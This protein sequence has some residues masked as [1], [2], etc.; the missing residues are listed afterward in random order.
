MGRKIDLIGKRFNKLIV[1]KEYPIRTPQGSV[2]WECLC[3][4]GNKTIVSG[5]NLRRN[6]T[7]SCGCQKQESAKPRLI[8][9]TGQKFGRLTVIKQIKGTRPVKWLCKCDCGNEVEVDGRNLRTEKTFS[10]GC[11]GQEQRFNHFIDYTGQKFGKLTITKLIEHTPG[12]IKWLCKCDC[13]GEIIL[14]SHSVGRT[15]SCGCLRSAGEAKI[16]EILKGA[17]ISFEREKSFEDLIY[18]DTKRKARFDFWVNNSFLVEF[19]GRQHFSSDSSGWND[20]DNLIKVQEH[21]KIKNDYCKEKK[22]PLK[23]IPYTDLNKI[24]LENILSDEYLI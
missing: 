5:D 20:K 3:D 21:D 13:G 10:C 24:T 6:H 11:Y 17:N 1:L 14:P 8:D 2:Q 18:P 16:V 15:L 4:C 7:K 12:N 22:I 19:D 23:R 9:I